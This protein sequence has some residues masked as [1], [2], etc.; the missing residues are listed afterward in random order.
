VEVGFA[1]MKILTETMIAQLDL[2]MEAIRAQVE[3]VMKK[4]SLGVYICD[5][6]FEAL[7]VT[8]DVRFG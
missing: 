8:P 6:M 1:R 5:V 4:S 2:L 3:F 7:S